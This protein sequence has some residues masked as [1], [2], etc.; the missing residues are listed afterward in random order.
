MIKPGNYLYEIIEFLVETAKINGDDY[1]DLSD[2]D[3]SGNTDLS[4]LFAGVRG[5]KE[6]RGLDKWDVS[7]VTD[8]SRMF[9]NSEFEIISDLSNWNVSNVD[10]MSSMFEGSIVKSIGN[11]SNWSVS[12]V[13]SMSSMF[14][15][16][17]IE[18]LGDISNW[19]VSSVI[20][21]SGMFE[22][23]PIKSLG[24]ISNWDVSNVI[25]FGFMFEGSEV[26]YVGD[27]SKWSSKF[28]DNCVVE[29]MLNENLYRYFDI[30]D[31]NKIFK[32]K[33]P[34]VFEVDLKATQQVVA[35]PISDSDLI[36]I[37]ESRLKELLV[38]ALPP[39]VGGYD[40]TA[41]YLEAFK[42]MMKEIKR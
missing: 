16:S 39:K 41:E 8:M 5:I 3:I 6:L 12:K 15:E 42:T 10:D 23:S 24:D 20:D 13:T 25:T 19:D 26:R 30:D 17:L 32:R 28:K 36:T 33:E 21:M 35:P 34:K 27:I 14:E 7:G 40:M 4:G 22:D 18:S 1:L 9:F 29:F 2:I 31:N 11:L 38:K 37:E